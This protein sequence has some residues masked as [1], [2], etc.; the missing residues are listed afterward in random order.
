MERAQHKD[1]AFRYS[2]R[3]PLLQTTIGTIQNQVQ[4]DGNPGIQSPGCRF[5]SINEYEDKCLTN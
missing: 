4:N 5:K 1:N 3:I 2:D